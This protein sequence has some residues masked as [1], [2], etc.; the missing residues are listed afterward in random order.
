MKHLLVNVSCETSDIKKQALKELKNVCTQCKACELSKTRTS[1]V[2]SDG[3]P[4]AEIMLIGEAPGADEDATGV[5]FVGRAGQLLNTF[6]EEAGISRKN[7]L[8]ICNTIKCR[9]PQ[10]RVPSN[11]EKL[12]C[13]SYLMGQIS[14][15]KPKIILLCGAT[16]ANS[17]INEDFKISQIRGKWLNLFEDV[18]VMAIFHPSYLLRNHSLEQGSPRWLMKKD[19]ENV[20]NRLKELKS[21]SE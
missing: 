3:S 5:P 15:V 12:A 4:D 14:I 11:E 20:K 19:L 13:Q 21:Q 10:N 17:F 16:A 1:M 9:P 6:L 2:F 8:Y 7:D 18:E